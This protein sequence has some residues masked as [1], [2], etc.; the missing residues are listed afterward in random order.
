MTTARRTERAPRA[1]RATAALGANPVSKVGDV[2][3]NELRAA[4]VRAVMVW[5][6]VHLF[7]HF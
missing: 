1:K 2:F 3:R 5:S 6:M 7:F 4:A